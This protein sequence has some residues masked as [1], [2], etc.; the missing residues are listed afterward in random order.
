MGLIASWK[1]NRSSWLL[2]GAAAL[3]LLAP[4]LRNGFP[5][6]YLDTHTYI[7]SG[8]TLSVP[9]DRPIFYGVWLMLSSLRLSLWLP[10][11]LQVILS[12]ALLYRLLTRF[13]DIQK[14]PLHYLLLTGLLSLLTG[15]GIN[16]TMLLPD[17]FSP[18]LV[19]AFVLLLTDKKY[20]RGYFV[21]LFGAAVM[22]NSH[23]LILLAM[24]L[25][26]ILFSWRNKTLQ[27]RFV[28]QS[29]TLIL[30]AFVLLSG[31][32]YLKFKVFTPSK[33]S[34][35]FLMGRL[36][37]TGVLRNYV[38]DHCPDL[39]THLCENQDKLLSGAS[40]FIWM[41]DSPIQGGGGYWEQEVVYKKIV[42]EVFTQPRYLFP[43][44][45]RSFFDGFHQLF[46][47]RVMIEGLSTDMLS[48][49][50]IEKHFTTDA[51]AARQSMQAYGADSFPLLNLAYQILLLFA[52]IVVLYGAIS[53]GNQF[54][55]AA[56]LLL[57]GIAA[58]AWV[59]ATFANVDSRL[60]ARMAW[61]I[62]VAAYIV[63]RQLAVKK[64]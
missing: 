35:F 28:L 21:I 34:T 10:V 40:E 29:A 61:L 59:T 46:L 39:P 31:T 15:A 19:I 52:L 53:L 42:R 50:Q 43:F 41:G 36:A 27:R 62:V 23:W 49:Q 57:L 38:A 9:F 2:V 22:H 45:Y 12:A 30:L 11:L 7:H 8:M 37:E 14:Q 26:Y 64:A 17:A 54:S 13:T 1:N 4:A 60:Q 3:L 51:T 24:S 33:A 25:V 47:N 20:E 56:A 48:F 63:Y 5:F 6:T 18:L 55:L 32:N 44:L 58:N 16:A